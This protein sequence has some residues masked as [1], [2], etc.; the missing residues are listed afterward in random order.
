MFHNQLCVPFYQYN[1]LIRLYASGP[2]THYDVLNLN[3]NCTADEIR[4]AFIKLSKQFH[5]DV[6]GAK[7]DPKDTAK[8]VKISE[9]YQVLSKTN[10][11]DA[12]DQDLLARSSGIHRGFKKPEVH[13][14]WEVKPNYD[15]NPGPYYGIK[16]VRK[17]S[18]ATIVMLLIGFAMTG[19]GIGFISVSQLDELSKEAGEHHAAVR[20]NAQKF[21]NDEQLKRMVDRMLNRPQ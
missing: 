5:P 20:V 13:R 6:K 8:F 21:G 11:R 3:K 7:T 17:V 10:T 1:Q 12:Y 16:G 9:A 19:V 2:P 4:Q 18:N 15:P 14:P